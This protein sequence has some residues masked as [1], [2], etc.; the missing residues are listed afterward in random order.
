MQHLSCMLLCVA[1][2]KLYARIKTSCK[3]FLFSPSPSS[4]ALFGATVNFLAS[5]W[6]NN[7]CVFVC[8]NKNRKNKTPKHFTR[9]IDNWWWLV[10]PY[11]WHGLAAWLTG[12]SNVHATI[13]THTTHNKSH[14]SF[15]FRL[16]FIRFLRHC[17]NTFL[18]PVT[19]GN[20]NKSETVFFL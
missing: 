11:L 9:T 14:F 2:G 5:S 10:F 3:V 17:S 16:L 7:M 4:S 15:T 18:C 1:K 19:K 6:P 20:A 8:A 12:L 13:H